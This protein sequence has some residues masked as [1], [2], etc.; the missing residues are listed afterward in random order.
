MIEGQIVLTRM[1]CDFGSFWASE[2]A[3]ATSAA[4]DVWKGNLAEAERGLSRAGLRSIAVEVA[5]AG[6]LQRRI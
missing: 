2:R 5:R 3:S 4:L 1:P 6:L